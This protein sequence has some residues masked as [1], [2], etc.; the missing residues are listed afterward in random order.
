MSITVS[1]LHLPVWEEI[2]QYLHVVEAPQ[3]AGSQDDPRIRIEV[4]G[5]SEAAVRR[6]VNTVMPCVHCGADNFCLRRRTPD[7]F[8]QGRLYSAPACPLSRRVGCS[9]GRAAELEY[10]RFKAFIGRN[11]VPYAQL[12][13]F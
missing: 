6:L 13:L 2:S 12:A 1:I 8:D 4:L 5:L 9:R 7:T 10:E 3:D 11:M